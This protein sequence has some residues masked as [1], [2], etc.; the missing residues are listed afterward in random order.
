[1]HRLKS[2]RPKIKLV[3]L[4]LGNIEYRGGRQQDRCFLS[5]AREAVSLSKQ[6]GVYGNNVIFLFDR[7]P[8]DDVQNFLLEADVGV[9]TYPDSLETRL[10]IGSRLLDFV[11]AGVPL[12]ASS[13][14]LTDELISNNKVGLTVKC[15]DTEVLARAIVRLADDENLRSECKANMRRLAESLTWEKLLQPLRDYCDNYGHFQRL[16]HRDRTLSYY[17]GMWSF[18]FYSAR[19]R[20]WEMCNRSSS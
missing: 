5:R 6:L 1:M 13:A 7:V 20:A 3:F 14:P 19:V 9:S 17:F 2:T 16:P 4:G 15:G 10:C 12:L 18:F 8:P 11:W